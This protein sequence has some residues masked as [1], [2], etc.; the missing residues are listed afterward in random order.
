ML[1]KFYLLFLLTS[2]ILCFQS[3]GLNSSKN[4]I[5]LDIMGYGN[6]ENSE[7][8]TFLRIVSEYEKLHPSV[9]INYS[10]LHDAEYH[11]K[12]ESRII[13][14][15]I[16]DI[17]YMG[18]DARWGKNWNEAG[19]QIDMKPYLDEKQYDYNLISYDNDK[20]EILYIPMGTANLCTVLFV[21]EKLLKQ[22]GLNMP[23][24][25]EDLK[26]MVPVAKKEG[27]Q[28]IGTH[29]ADSWVWGSCFL[30]TFIARTS[31]DATWIEKALSGEARFTDVE[32]VNALDIFSKMVQDG[33]LSKEA[34]LI[35]AD[36]GAKNYNKGKYLIY[37]S[38]QWDAANINSELQ[39]DTRLIAFPSLP[40]E[41]GC[42]KTVAATKQSGYGLTRYA[43]SNDT[44]LKAAMDFLNYY[45][46]QEETLLR[47]KKGEIV[48]PILKDFV[49]PDDISSIAK[50]KATL[51]MNVGITDVIDSFLTGNPNT[52]LCEGVQSLITES[53]TATQ[54]ASEIE[55]MV[56]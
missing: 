45:Y 10:L 8:I 37:V 39:Q 42:A 48:A 53:I 54:L 19:L 12:V 51:G 9:T 56:R 1:K 22:L 7:G 46:S 25:Y 11:Q 31:G 49:I 18:S 50:E 40:K 26:A 44:K 5:T 16:P 24:T 23:Q 13:A 14:G 47:L 2:F 35:D 21:N 43:L 3:C 36:T 4:N 38:G 27:I 28:V 29:G 52:V 15:N 34:V 33:I 20:E 32:F 17:A 41:K 6:E 30:S 55:S